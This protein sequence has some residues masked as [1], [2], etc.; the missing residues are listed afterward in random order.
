MSTKVGTGF[1]DIHGDFTTFS[2]QID[3]AL[4]P[5]LA[6]FES[7]G[8]AAATPIGALAAAATTAGVALFAIGKNFDDAN[9]RIRIGTGK[10]GKALKGLE[11]DFKAVVRNVP[12][13]FEE[14][15]K[16][17]TQLNQRLGLS[18]KPLQEIAEKSLELSRLTGTDLT[19]NIEAT[20]KAFNRWNIGAE[21]QSPVLDRLYRAFQAT[22]VP[23]AVLGT[24][25][26]RFATPLQAFGFN[27]NQ[28][29]ALLGAF[30]KAGLNTQRIMM[31]LTVALSNIAKTGQEPRE[32][33]AG[34]VKAIKDAGSQSE[35]TGIAIKLFGT[36][37][38][39]ELAAAIRSGR[40]ELDDLTRTIAGGKDTILGTAAATND[41]NEKWR[42]FRNRILV[43]LAPLALEVF[44][45][46]GTAM[47]VLG[48]IMAKIIEGIGA[49]VSAISGL[50]DAF[51]HSKTALLA[52]AAAAAPVVLVFTGMLV[53]SAAA[54]AVRALGSALIYLRAPLTAVAL[55]IEA[56]WITLAITAV[57]ALAAG[58]VIAYRESSRF[59][60]ALA[61]IAAAAQSVARAIGDVATTV[62]VKAR[63]IGVQI[64]NG[65]LAGVSDLYGLLKAAIEGQLVAA[66]TGL[67]PFSPV[68]HGGEI[69]IGR[70]L[71]E[72]AL[73]GWVYG[74]A[75]LPATMT[76]TIRAAVERA[77]QSVDGLRSKFSDAFGVLAD[78]ALTA[79]DAVMAKLKTPTEITLDTASFNRQ[80]KQL[81]DGVTDAKAKLSDA[82]G[83]LD[84]LTPQELADRLEP[85]Q[86][87][88]ADAQAKA[89]SFTAEALAKQ[90][91]PLNRKLSDAKAAQDKLTRKR[92]TT[93]FDASSKSFVTTGGETDAE[94]AQRQADAAQAVTD[95][96]DAITKANEDFT[97][98]Q[99]D[100]ARDVINAQKA[101]AKATKD[102][103]QDRVDAAKAVQAA[104]TG[105]DQAEASQREFYAGLKA[106]E[107][108][109]ELDASI[110]LRRRHFVSRLDA[111]KVALTR[112]GATQTEAN[113]RI[114]RLLASFGVD[115]QSSG[116]ALG[117]AFVTGLKGSEASAAKAAAAIAASARRVLTPVP[118]IDDQ[119]KTTTAGGGAAAG[120]DPFP[121]AK[122]AKIPEVKGLEVPR[123]LSDIGKGVGDALSD[124]S[125]AVSTFAGTVF[126]RLGP[127]LDWLVTAWGDT[128]VAAVDFAAAVVVAWKAT[129]KIAEGA[130][131]KFGK[132][133]VD[134]VTAVAV[135]IGGMVAGVIRTLHGLVDFVIGV[136]T[137][138]WKQAWHGVVEVVTGIGKLI[139]SAIAGGAAVVKDSAILLVNTFVL[140]FKAFVWQVE[141]IGP[142]LL[143]AVVDTIKGAAKLLF[144]VGKWMLDVI[145]GTIN[146]Y[147][148]LPGEALALVLSGAAGIAKAAIGELVKLG[149]WVVDRIVDGV[150]AGAAAI[151]SAAQWLLTTL[152]G[153]VTALAANFAN[154]GK[155]VIEWIAGG[156]RTIGA[157]LSG[158][159]AW[160]VGNL[161][162]GLTAVAVN[163]ANRGEDVIGWVA[164]GLRTVGGML[165]GFGSWL[166]G[167]LKTGLSA[168]AANFGNRGE[169]VIDWIAGGIRT[170]TDKLSNVP[171]WLVTTLK[172]AFNSVGKGL[173]SIGGSIIDFIVDGLKD[174][175]NE[176]IGFLN[177]IIH[178]IEKIPGVSIGDIPK[179]AQGG[180]IARASGGAID[181]QQFATGGQI[182]RGTRLTA[183]VVMMGEE[184]PAHPEFVIPTNPAYRQR[185]VGLYQQLGS[186][187]GMQAFAKG[188]ILG[189]PVAGAS[190]L[191]GDVV[192]AVT[193]LPGK[194]ADGIAGLIGPLPGV[195]DLPDFL[196][197]LGRFIISGVGGWIKD[198]VGGLFGS[199]ISV[200]DVDTPGALGRLS[201][202]V[203]RM[204]VID[205]RHQGYKYGGGHGDGGVDGFDCSGLVSEILRAGGF[206]G[207]PMTTDGLKVFGEGGD[208]KVI[209]IGVRGSTGRN[210]HT[211]MRIGNKYLESGGTNGGA[212]WVGG[213]DGSFPIHRH[214]AGFAQGGIFDR[215]GL[216]DP[217]SPLFA[218]WGLAQGGTI[219]GP[220]VG[221]YADGGVVPRDGLAYVHQGET[222]TPGNP[223]DGATVQVLIGGRVIDEIV[224]VKII[225]NDRRK[226]A[227]F[228]AGARA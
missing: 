144:D 163:F 30:G 66:L 92:G 71:G 203:K 81:A 207:G 197:G 122:P 56:N 91:A 11:S 182:R 172:T 146:A 26:A 110:A 57:A 186:E 179:L 53:A 165:A 87:T 222:I 44:G 49:V 147:A 228:F 65:V 101:I 151:G 217:D 169:D 36:R 125:S 119:P 18:G 55:L 131:E 52:A 24:Q 201:D 39:G 198:K 206:V 171:D 34:T 7:M 95:A 59:R 115:Y 170:I 183:P 127:A 155:D 73:R 109:K 164:G 210:A 70:P 123:Q 215:L 94:W 67:N 211:M 78:D 225:E 184:A 136:L 1:V 167:T 208:G 25:L 40:L 205:A 219:Q 96:Q 199:G 14:V 149:G 141:A 174:G 120:V 77:R 118:G 157:K 114:K 72:G 121:T 181:V 27:F 90:L 19:G 187:L 154:R 85:L 126:K 132:P 82:K 189:G 6:K 43:G 224:E 124:A 156:L 158:F 117:S 5:L 129:V 191:I 68:S 79:F 22:G 13:S 21:K 45:A 138:D 29:A 88:L 10:T 51:V 160:L 223:L 28:S 112:E 98:G 20:T 177:K 97:K 102:F 202:M 148:A 150:T 194:V 8:K 86:Q 108:R 69:Y 128:K 89:A 61:S 113:S 80:I 32:V 176:L 173:K 152:T 220:F 135:A 185:A 2:K 37:A 83:A 143:Q 162:A 64:V 226:S 4:G 153:A 15:S 12:D 60:A 103:G 190:S 193:S 204:D 75:D 130:W 180:S 133:I 31:S 196:K 38:G 200:A 84:A 46:I 218:G 42:I 54:L 48:P 3:A 105:V 188:G 111:L 137:G 23:V 93:A 106:K 139:G 140:G 212:K 63:N 35:A 175:A 192:H 213:W 159:A 216:T 58:F 145:V 209:T 33:L 214:P 100:S 116:D 134:A 47:D 161:K 195:G 168:L 62:Y 74:S 227:R 76:D 41:F 104:I 17:I 178:L 99:T 50:V 221:S 9:D 107:E 166:V 16:A 142:W